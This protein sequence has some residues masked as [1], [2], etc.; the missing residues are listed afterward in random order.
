MRP[1]RIAAI[2]LSL[3]CSGCASISTPDE[4]EIG[5]F[6]AL[7]LHDHG[8]VLLIDVR[9]EKE[10][11]S[12]SPKAKSIALQ[13][14]PDTWSGKVSKEEE[15]RFIARIATLETN[16]RQLVLL[17]QYGVRSRAAIAVLR[18]ARIRAK[19]VTDGYAGNESGP[20]WGAWE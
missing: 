2:A 14:G 3:Y 8:E 15:L 19:S 11:A 16:S 1:L 10:K 4:D 20:G 6:E 12:A 5:A 13:F 9:S 18:Q 7:A 17:C